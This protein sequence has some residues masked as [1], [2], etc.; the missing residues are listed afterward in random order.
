MKILCIG[1]GP[2]GLYFALL[3]KKNNPEHQITV[4]ERHRPYDTFGWGVVF[5]DNTFDHIRAADE[6]TGRLI[7]QAFQHWDQ[8]HIEFKGSRITS[9]GHGFCAIGRK[10]LL[11]ILQE[12]CED[13]GVRLIFEKDVADDSALALQHQADLVI[14]SDGMTSKIRSTYASSFVP[15]IEKRKCRFVWLGTR[16]KFDGFTF[17]FE[18]TEHGWFQSYAYRFDDDTSNFIIETAEDVWQ[19][20]GLDHAS[21]VETLDFCEKLFYRQLDGQRLLFNAPH[22]RGSGI[23]IKFARIVCEQW[24]HSN[25]ING[26]AVPVVLLGDAAHTS[27]YSVGVGTKLALEDA[28]ELARCLGRDAF[29]LSENLAHY[30][31]VRMAEIVKLQIVARNSM[32]WF[33]NVNRYTAMDAPQF[34]YSLL[35]RSQRLSH[36]GMRQRDPEYVQGYERWL[37]DRACQDA[38]QVVPEKAQPPMLMPFKLRGVLLPNRIVVSPMAQYSAQDGLVGDYHLV[39]L[40]ARAMGGA[41]LVFT[42]MVA[43]SALGRRTPGCPGLYQPEHISGWRR[44]TDF[45]HNNTG[46]MIAVQLGHAGPRGSTRR[47]WEGRN[48][49]LEQDNWPLLAAS[50]MQYLS[51]V[52]QAAT[53]ASCDQLQA[54]LA[55]FVSA[56]KAADAAGFDW[57]ELHCAHGFL[58]STFISPLTNQ[59]S[60]EY[61]GTLARRCRYPLQVFAAVRAVWPQHKPISVLISAHNWVEESISTDDAVQIA[62][63][64]KDAGADMINCASGQ[65]SNQELPALGRMF[66][67]PFSDRV[68]NEAD[69]PA[70]VVGA[71]EEAD[72]ANGIIAAGRADLCALGRPHLVQPMWT[73]DQAAQMGYHDM[74]WPKQYLIAKQSY[75][76]YWAARNARDGLK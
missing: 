68:R 72:H 2:A 13:L 56:A 33:E 61:G 42:E 57:L 50:D 25:Q 11:N 71:I 43:V 69:I 47:P 29:D 6:V 5:S 21:Q 12:R 53:Q 63:M 4:I 32:D 34:A 26:K 64:F 15:H 51:D 37:T 19:R 41:G 23:W 20:A 66:Q 7:C 49:P 60:D 35:T 62:R 48:L 58:L 30:Q 75:E 73:L 52:S 38:A 18:E 55:D 8:V 74:A 59:R 3:M 31:K 22:L 1:G 46:A 54:I 39:H 36:E 65:A 16:K 76:R 70:I 27:H 14:A 10:R 24:V 45:V 9:R 44:V 67:T 28:I 40:G 17:S